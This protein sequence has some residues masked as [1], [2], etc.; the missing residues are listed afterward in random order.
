[1]Y[2]GSNIPE[3]EIGFLVYVNKGSNIPEVEIGFLLYDNNDSDTDMTVEPLF[4]NTPTPIYDGW[5]GYYSIHKHDI[6]SLRKILLYI[7]KAGKINLYL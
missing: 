7:D 6:I 3:M 1:M 2:K 4:N 5:E